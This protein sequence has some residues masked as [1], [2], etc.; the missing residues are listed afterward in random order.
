MIKIIGRIS[1]NETLE[2]SA[3]VEEIYRLLNINRDRFIAVKNGVPV[4]EDE[5]V[6]PNDDLSIIEVFSGG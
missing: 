6:N 4:T 1:K 3:S 2:K 5:I